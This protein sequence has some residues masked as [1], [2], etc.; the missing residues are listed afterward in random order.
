MDFWFYIVLGGIILTIVGFIVYK[1]I[2]IVK[3]PQDEKRELIITYLKGL[4]ALAEKSLGEKR[5]Q[6]KLQMVENYFKE[7][8]PFVYKILLNFL[9][10]DALSDLIE[11]ALKE[12]K[13]S[14]SK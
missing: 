6:E 4:V 7:K 3:L 2:Q 10:E 14:F 8:A 12:I 1:I 11:K 9:K 13:E 5:G